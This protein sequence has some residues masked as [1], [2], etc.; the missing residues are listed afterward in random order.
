[1]KNKNLLIISFVAFI[2]CLLMLISV[3]TIQIQHQNRVDDIFKQY[4][5]DMG[6]LHNNY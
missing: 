1:M 2:F 5:K 4:E 3:F 6:E